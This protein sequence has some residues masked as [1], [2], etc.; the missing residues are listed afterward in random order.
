TE[1]IRDATGPELD[2]E[3][4]ARAGDFVGEFLRM[5]TEAAAS[6][7]LLADLRSALRPLFS[8]SRTSV[9]PPPSDDDLRR[10]LEAARVRGAALLIQGEA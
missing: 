9:L 8:P 2:L 5:G 10:W 1:S 7:E 3:A 6:T 4:R